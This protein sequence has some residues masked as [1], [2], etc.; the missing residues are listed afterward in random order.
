MQL[1]LKSVA[2]KRS[3]RECDCGDHERRPA[4]GDQGLFAPHQSSRAG[5]HPSE[6]CCFHLLFK[7]QGRNLRLSNH[8]DCHVSMAT[9]RK[10]MRRLSGFILDA[11]SLMRPLVQACINARL[12]CAEGLTLDS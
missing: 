10:M 3:M 2:Q 7:A 6:I 9:L 11:A 12:P 1:K 4:G 8:I 5:H